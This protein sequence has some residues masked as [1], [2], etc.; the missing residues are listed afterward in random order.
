MGLGFYLTG[1]FPSG[2]ADP[3]IWLGRLA[4]WLEEHAAETLESVRVGK[5]SE[6]KPGVFASLHPAAEEIEFIVPAPGQ[7]VTSAKTSTV[8]PGYHTYACDLLHRLGADLKVTWDEPDQESGTGDETGYFHRGDRTR[9]ETEYLCWLGALAVEIAKLLE[10]GSEYMM[11]SMPIGYRYS[12]HGPVVTTLG[13]RNG[14]WLHSVASHPRRGIDIFPWWD[15]GLG[16]RFH[17]GR[18]LCRMWQKVAWRVPLSESEGKLLVKTH[19]DLYR[20]YEQDPALAYPWCEWRELL[21]HIEAYFGYIEMPGEDIEPQVTRRARQR[22][23]G[24]LIGYRRL[25]RRVDLTAGWSIEVPG[26]MADEW[27]TPETWRGWDGQRTVWFTSYAVT[28][29]D[30]SKPAAKELLVKLRLPRGER[31]KHQGE[32]TIGKATLAPYEEE[33]KHLWQLSGQSAV[34]GEIGVFTIVFED[35]ADR[36][37]AVSVWRSIEHEEDASE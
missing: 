15:D 16:A 27:D 19:R 5:D 2:D 13:P 4:S 23:A 21:D 31:L 6:S 24:P 3:V 26:A 32:R 35:P 36:D 34:D 20:A 37:W 33:G 22:N 30:G 17:L 8:G 25:A 28:D 12:N 18:A 10:Q 29:A 14:N 11:L 7:L 1:T 9:V